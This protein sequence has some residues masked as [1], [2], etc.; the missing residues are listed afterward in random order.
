MNKFSN[1][2]GPVAQPDS[3]SLNLKDRKSLNILATPVHPRSFWCCLN[4]WKKII[5]FLCIFWKSIFTGI[6]FCGLQ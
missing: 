3:V 5:R 2:A 4:I 6:I 1:L